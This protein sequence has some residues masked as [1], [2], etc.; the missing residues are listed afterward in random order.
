VIGWEIVALGG[1]RIEQCPNFAEKALNQ[2]LGPL[3]RLPQK[4][5]KKIGDEAMASQKL[6][7]VKVAHKNGEQRCRGRMKDFAPIFGLLDWNH[8]GF[9]GVC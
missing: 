5:R 9:L 4:L 2:K 7:W 6:C 1:T 3:Y 8:N